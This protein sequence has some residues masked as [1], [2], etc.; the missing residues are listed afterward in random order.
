MNF[1]FAKTLL[2]GSVLTMGAFGLVACGD[3]S[4]SGPDNS[5][6]GPV[7]E[8]PTQKDAIIQLSGMGSMD[9]DTY[10]KFMG[11]ASLD[12]M[13]SSSQNQDGLLF[14]NVDFKVGTLDGEKLNV[15]ENLNIMITKPITT[16]SDKI[17]LTQMGVQVD[18]TDPAFTA[19]G[20]YV[21]LV[22]FTA[23]DGLKD[24]SSSEM[25]SFTRPESYCKVNDPTPTPEQNKTEVSLTPVEVVVSTNLYPSL[26]LTTMEAEAGTAGDLVFV[27]TN[28]GVAVSTGNG[29]VVTPIENETLTPSN[30]KD[31]YAIG[32]W[33]EE[34]NNRAAVMS[35]FMFRNVAGT[36][37][38]A[39]VESGSSDGLIYVAK[40]AAFNEATGAGFYA[41]AVVGAEPG[42]NGDF[43]M[44][45]KVYK[46][47]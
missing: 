25:V 43:T 34:V 6:N 15:L 45:L 27:K 41:F 33:P 35:D 44:T 9:L 21:M 1:K 14:T 26:N 7:V 10:I 17:N 19:C 38:P 22:T 47:N 28:A 36:S 11:S 2:M 12:A 30:Y 20:N 40:T 8:I 13:D 37:I 18:L 5:G 24:F 3:D 4:S 31:D 29:T 42:N 16:Y 23:N 32:Y 46:A 39:I